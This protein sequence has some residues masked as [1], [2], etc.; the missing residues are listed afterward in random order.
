MAQPSQARHVFLLRHGEAE[1]NVS[2]EDVPDAPLTAQGRGQANAWQHRMEEYDFE[3]V[4]ISP[5]TRAIQTACYAFQE[6]ECPLTVVRSARELWWDDVANQP[7]TLE[8]V[9]EV[10]RQL[11]RGQEVQ[12]LKAA[13]AIKGPSTE[14]ESI[15][16]FRTVLASRPERT[17]AVVTHWGVINALCGQGADNCEMMECLCDEKGNV[18]FVRK[19]ISPYWGCTGGA[20]D[21]ACS[22]G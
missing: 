14:A 4:L 21:V 7:G 11:P 1:H 20:L 8:S 2:D 10:L 17:I 22:I 13:L 18:T 16:E 12:G 9:S 5:L 6:E 15:R 19:H 3:V